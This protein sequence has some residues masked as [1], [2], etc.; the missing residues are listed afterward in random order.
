MTSPTAPKRL[1]AAVNSYHRPSLC[2]S[3]A[4]VAAPP[5][6]PGQGLI[7]VGSPADQSNCKFLENTVRRQQG[8]LLFSGIPDVLIHIELSRP[9]SCGGPDQD[10]D[11][12][13]LSQQVNCSVR[14][15]VQRRTLTSAPINRREVPRLPHRHPRISTPQNATTTTAMTKQVS[16]RSYK[17]ANFSGV[18]ARCGYYEPYSKAYLWITADANVTLP[19]KVG[20]G[21]T[22]EFACHQ[23]WLNAVWCVVI[24]Y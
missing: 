11:T 15:N 12:G 1:H 9:S 24:V 4:A 3:R 13:Q 14:L 5:P 20:T 21:D 6:K 18:G 17:P 19:V 22:R 7:R 16:K 2:A 23:L 10:S 8:A